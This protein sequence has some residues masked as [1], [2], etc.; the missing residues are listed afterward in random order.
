MNIKELA[1]LADVSISTVSKIINNKDQ[2]I[3][4]GTRDKVLSLAKKYNYVPYASTTG[5][6]TKSMT[7]G[8]L[9]S[10]QYLSNGTLLGILD[11]VSEHGYLV[12]ICDIDLQTDSLDI[13]QK[14]SALINRGVNGLIFESCNDI[15]QEKEQLVAANIPYVLF[16]HAIHKS[17]WIHYDCLG[18]FSTQTLLDLGHKE[19]VC[20]ASNTEIGLD[21][22]DGYKKC[23][24]ESNISLNVD[25][26][27]EEITDTLISKIAKHSVTAAVCL[28]PH[29]ANILYKKII[30]LHYRIPDDFSIITVF[31]DERYVSSYPSLS[32]VI[33]PHKKHGTYL[34]KEIIQLV[35]TRDESLSEFKYESV[36][37]ST[38]SVAP[39][40]SSSSDKILVVGS[41]HIDNYFSVSSLP[42]SG[43][44]VNSSLVSVNV[45]GKGLNQSVGLSKLGQKAALIGHAGDDSNS[46]MIFSTL[47]SY[48]IIDSGVS[49]TPDF[50]TGQGY[51]FV[52][53]DGESVISIMS[54]ANQSLTK[55]SIYCNSNLFENTSHCLIQT[56]IPMPAVAAALTLSKKNKVTTILKPA[57]CECLDNDLLPYIDILVPNKDELYKICPETGSLDEM[58]SYFIER[59]VKHIIVTLGENGCYVKSGN[60]SC[61]IPAANFP[62]IDNTGACD[63]FISALASYLKNGYDIVSAAKIAT[64]AAGFSVSRTGVIPS[65]ISKTSLE[66]YIH[67]KEPCLLRK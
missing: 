19:I 35:E 13:S 50:P 46:D 60:I 31:D 62:A 63:A 55:E 32:G 65:L 26:L 9:A 27:M 6:S 37:T 38:Q 56:E 67:Q 43:T 41:I 44:T 21:F 51:I 7:I 8:V 52:R 25:Y 20:L 49:R 66:V 39:P 58:A 64:Y 17:S 1:K 3:S 33:V 12:T 23:L 28:N 2:S 15:T 42:E 14:I 40:A 61:N 4:P 29:T 57:A 36:L 18:Y 54:G 24:F 47:Q 45:G 59:G 11:E 16:G 30:S 22:S 34:G 48:N 53:P 10:Y 5:S